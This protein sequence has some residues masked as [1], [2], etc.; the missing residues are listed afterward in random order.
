MRIVNVLLNLDP[1]L[2]VIRSLAVTSELVMPH[3]KSYVNL[4]IP[5]ATK[6]MYFLD[7]VAFFVF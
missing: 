4:S 1:C 3:A 5:V 2:V 7:V 6:L